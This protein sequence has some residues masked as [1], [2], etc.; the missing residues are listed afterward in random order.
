M[1]FF[2]W[3][4]WW[5]AA[6]CCWLGWRF[7][8]GF[9]S[10]EPHRAVGACWGGWGPHTPCARQIGPHA[11][12][13]T[14]PSRHGSLRCVWD[15][16]QKCGLPFASWLNRFASLSFFRVSPHFGAGAHGFARAR[17]EPSDNLCS[18]CAEDGS[19]LERAQSGALSFKR[20]N[21]LQAKQC[22][23]NR[24]IE[25]GNAASTQQT[26]QGRTSWPTPEWPRNKKWPVLCLGVA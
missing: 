7:L 5:R 25:R 13:P 26:E 18:Q 10:G 22:P 21:V 16:R 11:P 6:L 12:Q 2:A 1:P 3:L 4:L 24:Q 15:R 9:C 14:P 20:S 19:P 8:P 23:S 17:G